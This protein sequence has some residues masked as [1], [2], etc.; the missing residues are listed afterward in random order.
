M[1]TAQITEKVNGC[2][3]ALKIAKGIDPIHEAQN[4][5][6]APSVRIGLILN[7]GTPRLGIK[8]LVR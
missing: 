5:L 8:R 3:I 7:F 4:Y 1:N 2:A 6:K